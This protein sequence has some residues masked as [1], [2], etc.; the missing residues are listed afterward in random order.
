ME[1][2]FIW[3]M[4]NSSSGVNFFCLDDEATS[5]VVFVLLLLPRV[6]RF[7]L[8]IF[9][10]VDDADDDTKWM[11]SSLLFEWAADLDDFL[12]LTILSI[13]SVINESGIWMIDDTYVSIYISI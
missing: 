10:A 4:M 9:V 5:L 3:I 8:V 12:V 6:D 7:G 11:S 2:I 13:K 1:W